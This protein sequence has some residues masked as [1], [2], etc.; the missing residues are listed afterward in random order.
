MDRGGTVE[1]ASRGRLSRAAARAAAALVVWAPKVSPTAVRRLYAT[2]ARGIVDSDLIVE[3]GASLM[4]RCEAIIA[5][6]AAY[7]RG[8]IRCPVCSG[9]VRRTQSIRVR[10]QV[11][12]CS[13]CGWATT[14]GLYFDTFSNP[15]WEGQVRG[16]PIDEF[17]AFCETFRAARSTR[18]RL[19]AIDRLINV[20]HAALHRRVK[21]STRPAAAQLIE[22]TVTEVLDLLDDISGTGVL[23]VS[24]EE[25]ARRVD[26]RFRARLGDSLRAMRRDAALTGPALARRARTTAGVICQIEIGLSA[27]PAAVERIARELGASSGAVDSLVDAARATRTPPDRKV[28][29]TGP[30]RSPWVHRLG[31]TDAGPELLGAKGH[32]LS[33]MVRAGRPVPPGFVISAA[34]C[35]IY[36]ATGGLPDGLWADVRQAMG[37]LEAATGHRFGDQR[38]P[39]L[40]SVRSGA[41]RSMPGMLETILNVGLN[42]ELVNAMGSYYGDER[43]AVDAHRRLLQLFSCAVHGVERE[44]FEHELALARAAA[45]VSRDEDVPLADLRHVVS[46]FEEICDRP[47]GL[48]HDPWKQLEDAVLAVFRSWNSPRARVYRELEAIPADLG[49]AVTVQSM[50]LGSLTGASGSGVAISR[51]PVSGRR[52]LWGDFLAGSQGTDVVGGIR[53]PGVMTELRD[54]LPEVHAE[55]LGHVRALERA[56]RGPVETEFTVERGRLYLLQVRPARLSAAGEV[57]AA[58]EMVDEGLISESDAVLRIDGSARPPNRL[59]VDVGRAGPPLVS[60]VAASAGAATGRIALDCEKARSWAAESR[61]VVLFRPETTSDDVEGVAASQGLIT[62]TGGAA[63][64]GALVARA[65]GLP[66]VVGVSGIKIDLERREARC[67]GVVLREGVEVTIDGSS[68][69]IYAGSVPCVEP[70]DP[71]LQR[72][73]TWAQPPETRTSR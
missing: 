60:G 15:T 53:A 24:A 31:R 65:L 34:A 19:L 43:A 22:G 49:T 62:L 23:Q 70:D 36:L 42:G 5:A 44:R 18:E 64:H 25:C 32:R 48:P 10:G 63:S 40:V 51:D 35:R 12:A 2:D 26:S 8:L 7:R 52:G 59:V 33:E 11:V 56:E 58:V 41:A 29:P 68:G 45:G 30:S 3:V 50:V 9:E 61:S 55:L 39:L 27:P 17:A 73:R 4:A 20:F 67:G 69:A 71:Y 28:S 46:R 38:A 21:R 6:S 16:G 37:E 1:A 72:I 57:R 54:L 13:G 47:G 66:C 14:W